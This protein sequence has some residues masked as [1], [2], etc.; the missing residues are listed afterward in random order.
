MSIKNL[1]LKYRCEKKQVQKVR[2]IKELTDFSFFPTRKF[3]SVA[4]YTFDAVFDVPTDNA[5]LLVSR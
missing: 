5:L 2:Y 3:C 1:N 4:R